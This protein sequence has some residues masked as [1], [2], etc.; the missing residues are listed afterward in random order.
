MG[1]REAPAHTPHLHLSGNCAVHLVPDTVLS[2]EQFMASRRMDENEIG[3]EPQ[4]AVFDLGDGSV[5][6]PIVRRCFDCSSYLAEED[7]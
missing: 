6:R 5:Q 4:G 7:P 1:G 3:V 2:E